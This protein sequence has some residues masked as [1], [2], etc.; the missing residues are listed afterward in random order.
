MHVLFCS[1]TGHMKMLPAAQ[2]TQ[3][4]TVGCLLSVTE[5]VGIAVGL[6]TL[7]EFIG[8][9]LG[10]GFLSPISE[11]Q[12]GHLLNMERFLLNPSHSII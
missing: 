6:K 4:R 10:C 8:S 2:S 9:N 1:L 7:R 5:Q 11:M 3:C 12:I